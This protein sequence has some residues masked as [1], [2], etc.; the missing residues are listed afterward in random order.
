MIQY[1]NAPDTSVSI[2]R[3]ERDYKKFHPIRVHDYTYRGFYDVL[4]EEFV[5]SHRLENVLVYL[6]DHPDEANEYVK[7]LVR[8]F[9]AVSDLVLDGKPL[10]ESRIVIPC[11]GFDQ[12]Y[13]IKN[14]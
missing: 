5:F 6:R 11:F 9:N 7:D 8:K 2:Q 3:P 4:L 13:T 10:Q 14:E 1:W 12:K